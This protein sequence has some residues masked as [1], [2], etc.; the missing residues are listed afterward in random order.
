MKN[1]NDVVVYI[2]QTDNLSDDSIAKIRELA[3]RFSSIVCNIKVD[4]K[5]IIDLPK[6][7]WP[8]E[9]WLRHVVMSLLPQDIER[10]L[11][12]DCDVIVTKSLSSFYNMDMKNNCYAATMD[13][14]LNGAC[15]EKRDEQRFEK[16]GM[17]EKDVYVN[18]GILLI[19]LS[20]I[21]MSQYKQE[22]YW[23]YARMHAEDLLYPDQD[24]L[25]GMFAGKILICNESVYNFQINTYSFE[26]TKE[27]LKKAK[28]IHYTSFR[29]WDF[30]YKRI[31]AGNIWWQ[32]AVQ[33][34]IK[35]AWKYFVWL[36]LSLIIV[37][38]WHLVRIMKKFCMKILKNVV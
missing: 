16:L 8:T 12:L 14:P 23:E 2:F 3:K 7:G 9:A 30:G 34:N 18:A 31:R 5:D 17:T 36:L 28:I 32:Y 10:I 6:K 25:N 20:Q 22:D 29:P 33:Y 13:R 1:N 24:L 27:Y 4:T 38:P 11:Y 21:R 26:E 37:V 19:N 35:Y 15:G